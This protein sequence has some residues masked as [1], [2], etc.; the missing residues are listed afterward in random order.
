[1]MNR[2]MHSGTCGYTNNDVK[3][4]TKLDIQSH[5]K[6]RGPPVAKLAKYSKQDDI[7]WIHK[8]RDGRHKISPMHP[9]RLTPKTCAPSS[10][11]SI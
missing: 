5:H 8:N 2:T 4:G 10:L 1:M 7:S 6:C 11:H 9:P 3:K